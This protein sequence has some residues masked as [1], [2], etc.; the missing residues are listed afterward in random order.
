MGKKYILTDTPPPHT[1]THSFYVSVG[2]GSQTA[3]WSRKNCYRGMGWRI[4]IFCFCERCSN[5]ST[6]N[7][8][9]IL[10]RWCADGSSG[11]RP[12]NVLG[13][14]KYIELGSLVEVTVNLKYCEFLENQILLFDLYLSENRA[15]H[16]ISSRTKTDALIELKLSWMTWRAFKII[17]T[18]RLNDKVPRFESN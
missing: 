3:N 14:F 1:H 16:H 15:F 7:R 6:E 17:A 11:K 10:I 18:S 5:V 12:C 13:C 8:I 4:Q 2:E 9:N